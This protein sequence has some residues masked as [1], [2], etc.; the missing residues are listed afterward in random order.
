MRSFKNPK[1]IPGLTIW[2][3]AAD[4]T[5]INNGQVVDNGN[6][7]SFRDKISNIELTNSQGVNGPSYSI[8]A[9]NGRNAISIPYYASDDVGLKALSA[10]N[11]NGL[12]G[13]TFSMFCVYKPTTTIQDNSTFG[14]Q[15]Y[16]VTIYSKARWDAILGGSTGPGGWPNRAIYIGDEGG[17]SALAISQRLNP[18]GRY[19]EAETIPTT[20]TTFWTVYATYGEHVPSRAQIVPTSL[21]KT[22]LTQVRIQ[23]GLKKM[24]FSFRGYDF[25]DDFQSSKIYADRG[26][27]NTGTVYDV[28]LNATLVIGS[29][30]SSGKLKNN[31]RYPLEGF[32]CEFLYYNRYLSDS[33]YDTVSRYLKKKWT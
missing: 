22:C 31:S 29:P 13:L 17:G 12:Q 26:I 7:F 25:I 8:G 24:G 11:V 16:V 3:D 33:E 6:V 23:S 20:P 30:W 10:T 21:N 18:S 1:N 28:G 32:F 5:T 4:P 19:V 9:V 15:K 14:N 27:K 2:L